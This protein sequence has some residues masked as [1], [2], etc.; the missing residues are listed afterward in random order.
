MKRDMDL[1]R[2][3]LLAIPRIHHCWRD[4]RRYADSAPASSVSVGVGRV[5]SEESMGELGVPGIQLLDASV[6][7]CL[8]GRCL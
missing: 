8:F 7:S 2:E 5:R 1:V 6:T 3:I 4:P